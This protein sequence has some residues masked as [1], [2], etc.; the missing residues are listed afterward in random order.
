MVR[1]LAV[2][3]GDDIPVSLS[4]RRIHN[5]RLRLLHFFFMPCLVGGVQLRIR[6]LIAS[7]FNA[8]RASYCDVYA[9]SLSMD[10]SNMAS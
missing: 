4:F 8:F 5:A 2:R 6:R 7:P 1:L 9:F 3:I 10:C